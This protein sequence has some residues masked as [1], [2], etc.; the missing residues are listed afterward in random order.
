MKEAELI[1]LITIYSY[2]MIGVYYFFLDFISPLTDE[3]SL[4]AIA[5]LSKTGLM[6]KF[7]AALVSYTAL[8][9]RN[10]GSKN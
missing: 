4:I 10:Y 5:Y 7:G 2:P 8:Y 9:G 3:V 1:R 6:N